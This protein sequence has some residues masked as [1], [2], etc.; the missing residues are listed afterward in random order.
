MSVYSDIDITTALAARSIVIYPFVQDNLNGASIDVTLGEWFYATDR[1]GNGQFYNPYDPDDVARYFGEPL[2]A[3]SNAD[4]CA[5]YGRLPFVGIPPECPI[6]VLRPKERI[7]AHTHEFIGMHP[8]GVPEMRARSTIGRNGVVVCKDAGWGDPGYINRWTMEIQNDNEHA[9]PLPVGARVAQI[10]FHHTGPVHRV[11][12]RTG[13]Y[14]QGNDLEDLLRLW[15]PSRMLP[16][17]YLDVL[18]TPRVEP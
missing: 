7:L 11:Y 3:I 17:A 4:W 1:L 15:T 12:G 9:I 18:K 10:A 5:K 6:I 16:R 13:K 14:Q 2:R 8:P